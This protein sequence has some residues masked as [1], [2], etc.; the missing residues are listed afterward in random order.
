MH[1]TVTSQNTSKAVKPITSALQLETSFS[2]LNHEPNHYLMI[3]DSPEATIA[4]PT[5]VLLAR[6]TSTQQITVHLANERKHFRNECASVTFCV[7]SLSVGLYSC[8][9]HKYWHPPY[10]LP[11][12]LKEHLFRALPLRTRPFIFRLMFCR[13]LVWTYSFCFTF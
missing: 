7:L 4:P 3:S 1:E 9:L 5:C 13:L 11:R 10:I 2:S 6:M 12:I 8:F